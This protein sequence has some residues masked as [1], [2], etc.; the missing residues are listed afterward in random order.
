MSSMNRTYLHLGLVAAAFVCAAVIW[1]AAPGAS[2]PSVPQPAPE[3][4]P[5]AKSLPLGQVVLFNSGVGY[6]Q[7]EGAIEDDTR[8]DLQFPTTD[9]NDLLKSLVLQDLG[10]GKITA[11]SYDGQE[12]I[13]RTLKSFSLDLTYNPTLGQL[14]N[15]AR[16][17]K[18]EVVMQAGNAGAPG[19]LT[20]AVV[21]MESQ[22]DG[23]REIHL[24]NLLCSDGVRCVNLSQV[25][26]VRFLDPTLDSEFHRALEV[27]A[28]AHNGLK[29]NVSF[30]FNGEGKRTVKIG[31]VLEA[32][33]WKSSYR[34]V[35]DKEGKP[36]LQGWAVVENTTDEDWKDIRMA[37]VSSRPISFQMDLY[38]PLFVPRPVV[39]PEHFASLRPPLHEGAL[40]D[41][42]GKPV[43]MAGNIGLAGGIGGIAGIGGG[44]FGNL[45]FQG[46]FQGAGNIG[47]GGGQ[48]GQL[49]QFGQFGQ[50][51]FQGGNNRYQGGTPIPPALGNNRL[52]YE[53]LQERRKER[54]QAKEEAKKV[55]SAIAEFDPT[56]SIDPKALA[57]SV[58]DQ[59]QHVI[60]HKVSLNRQRSALL[61]LVNQEVAGERVSIYND[62]VHAKFPLRG[63]KFKNATGQSLMQ[64]PVTVYEGGNYAG[65]ARMPDLQPNEERLLSYAIDQAV[66]V[67][68]EGKGE[69]DELT[70]VRIVR[71]LIE[72]THRQRSA[73]T[74]LIKNR[75]TRDRTLIVEHPVHADW[76]L[77]GTHTVA[78]RSR[79]FYRF[80][81]KLAPGETMTR[82][83]VEERTQGRQYLFNAASEQKVALLL[84]TTILSPK[85]KEALQK[86]MT[87]SGRLAETRRERARLAEELK[88]INDEQPRLRAN[89]DKL[90]PGS[91]LHKRTLDKLDK[92]ETQIETLQTQI[93]EQQTKE[94]Q[95]Q[96]EFEDFVAS[97]TFE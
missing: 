16:G 89:L 1:A 38:Q 26:R 65:D 78:E 79:D 47:F 57:E 81:W 87:F 43:G 84:R 97:L 9:V 86:A 63:L 88:A 51:G 95:Q 32:P 5:P 48:L 46:G 82:E 96:K 42:Q 67:K 40:T 17:E 30:E 64:G 83:I 20:G 36:K 92:Q 35:F 72:E 6:F 24:L 14:L 28:S 60:D 62:K 39:E 74:Y 58:G 75:S 29:K 55:G 53:Q 37:L 44:G 68:T 76:K 18:V 2:K 91:A 94:K 8:L 7:R 59:V 33:M 41:N 22:P 61:P 49:G 34:L 85:L 3:Q 77:A 70:A 69:P 11:V 54:E 56:E 90:P 27:L 10:H 80:S 45:G 19:T 15:Q 21:G 73:T 4:K 25:Q 93:A 13:D 52:T 66:E 12:P 71:G 31:Y 23:T 50:F